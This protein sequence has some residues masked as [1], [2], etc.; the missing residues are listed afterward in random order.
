MPAMSKKRPPPKTAPGR[1]HLLTWQLFEMSEEHSERAPLSVNVD[2]DDIILQKELKLMVGKTQLPQNISWIY[3][4]AR[5]TE[6]VQN[7]TEMYIDGEKDG[8]R[9]PMTTDDMVSW[10]RATRG[11]SPG[12]V[13]FVESEFMHGMYQALAASFLWDFGFKW[14]EADM[15]ALDQ[16]IYDLEAIGT[17]SASDKAEK[18]SKIKSELDDNEIHSTWENGMSAGEDLNAAIFESDFQQMR[19]VLGQGEFFLDIGPE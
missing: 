4:F 8:D 2:A 10:C 19:E 7:D 6:K 13:W 18:L 3:K 11:V 16:K 17:D 5:L 15:D 14:L 1:P 9:I 12:P